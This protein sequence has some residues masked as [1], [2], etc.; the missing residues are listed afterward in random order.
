MSGHVGE[1][2]LLVGISLMS[3]EQVQ[4]LALSVGPPGGWPGQTPGRG[5]G[6]GTPLTH[7]AWI[8]P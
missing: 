8:N 5:R 4:G 7:P 2:I 6:P 3:S 1:V